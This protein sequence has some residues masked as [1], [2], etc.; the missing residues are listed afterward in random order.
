MPPILIATKFFHLGAHFQAFGQYAHWLQNIV[1]EK[2]I[3]LYFL[4]TGRASKSSETP[5]IVK[6][7][8]L[9]KNDFASSYY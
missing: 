5:L 6:I 3:L 2:R 1:G 4:G 7:I 9:S 8:T